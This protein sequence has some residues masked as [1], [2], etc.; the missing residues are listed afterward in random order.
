MIRCKRSLSLL[1]KHMWLQMPPKKGK[2][3][4]TATRTQVPAKRSRRPARRLIEDDSPDE[5]VAPTEQTCQLPQSVEMPPAKEYN[6]VTLQLYPIVI[7]LKV[8]ESS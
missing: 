3:Q 2:G 6:I 1:S 8:W 4:H 7:A 5:Q